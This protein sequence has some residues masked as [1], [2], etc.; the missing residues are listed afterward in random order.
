MLPNQ[1]LK[2]LLQNHK[3]KTLVKYKVI[4]LLFKDFYKILENR[5]EGLIPN[6]YNCQTLF[7]VTFYNY[8]KKTFI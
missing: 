6:K 5:K 1:S 4:K 2:R 8:N 3:N 7:S